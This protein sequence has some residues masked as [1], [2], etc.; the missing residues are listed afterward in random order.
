VTNS[1]AVLISLIELAAAVYVFQTFERTKQASTVD[2]KNFGANI[3][4]VTGSIAFN[5]FH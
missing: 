3:V 5:L 2:N 4:F 1:P